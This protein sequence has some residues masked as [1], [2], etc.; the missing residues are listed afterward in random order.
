RCELGSWAVF[1]R[2]ARRARTLIPCELLDCCSR[3]G[4]LSDTPASGLDDARATGKVLVVFAAVLPCLLVVVAQGGVRLGIFDRSAEGR[5]I[6]VG[7]IRKRQLLAV[8]PFRNL[9]H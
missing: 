8:T 6:V 7:E 4:L 3:S 1:S 5:N 2:A 9:F